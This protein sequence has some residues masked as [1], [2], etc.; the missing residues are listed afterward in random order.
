MLFRS[1]KYSWTTKRKNH[2]VIFFSNFSPTECYSKA[3]E[4]YAIGGIDLTKAFKSLDDLMSRTT[5]SMGNVEKA[6]N[7]SLAKIDK[8]IASTASKFGITL[9]QGMVREFQKGF[10]STEKLWKNTANN[11]DSTTS[12]LVSKYLNAYKHWQGIIFMMML[13]VQ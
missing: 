7:A 8:S 9:Q 2:P 6:V 13:M 1:V 12:S 4:V 10:S 3:G 11:M 5:K